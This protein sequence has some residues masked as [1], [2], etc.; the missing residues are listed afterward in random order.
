MA[1]VTNI[2]TLLVDIFNSVLKFEEKALWEGPFNDV[3][4]TEVHTV[5][6][7]GLDEK[8][9]MSEIAKKLNIT[10][11]T[12]TTAINN[13]SRKGY[14][15]RVKDNFDKRV[16]F[17]RLTKKGRFLFRVHENFHEK[18]VSFV[19]ENITK[20]E[21]EVLISALDKLYKMLQKEILD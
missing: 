7:I 1:N 20:E 4:I 21:E 2:N 5:E 12:L 17:I 18:M 15:E 8:K 11:G 13:L 9:K 19:I 6:A 10:L 3:S 14:V 16:V